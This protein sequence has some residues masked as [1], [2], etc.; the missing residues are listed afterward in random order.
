MH[1]SQADI[2]LTN[3]LKQAGKWL[4]LPVLDHVIVGADGFYSFA[5]EGI[6]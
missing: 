1:P 6:L 3:T 2:Q 4:D 5:Q